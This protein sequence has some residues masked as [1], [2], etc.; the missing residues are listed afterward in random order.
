MMLE[1][2]QI[3]TTA[4]GRRT[5]PFPK[6]TLNSPR[7][8]NSTMARVDAWLLA[9]AVAEAEARSDRF[10]LLQFQAENPRGIPQASKDAM[11]LYLFGVA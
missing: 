3:V 1:S 4:T 2:G 10:N 6:V 7:A 5:T 9:N 11:E 8:A